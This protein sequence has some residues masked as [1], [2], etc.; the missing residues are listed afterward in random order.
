MNLFER[1]VDP[2]L[3]YAESKHLLQSSKYLI[4]ITNGFNYI[5]DNDTK[6]RSIILKDI[7][8][9]LGPFK[10]NLKETVNHY[11]YSMHCGQYTTH[12]NCC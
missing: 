10:L 7:N 8:I 12:V 9:I 11:G 1:N 3:C 2:D 4:I 6:Y 5:N